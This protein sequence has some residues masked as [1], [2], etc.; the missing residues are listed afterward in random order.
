MK[1]MLVER[2]REN[3]QEVEDLGPA[4][5]ARVDYPDFA[6]A[7]ARAVRTGT[8]ERGLLVCGSGIGMSIAAN[9]HRGGRAVVAMNGTQAR[10]SR[11]HNDVNVLC[12]GE[13]LVGEELAWDIVVAFIGTE[14]EG[15]RH[16]QRIAKLDEVEDGDC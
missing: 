10:L 7:V 3:G 9:R 6:R 15:G 11:A 12:L 8:A 1:S 14:F 4:T 13:R 2:L 16:A 5:D